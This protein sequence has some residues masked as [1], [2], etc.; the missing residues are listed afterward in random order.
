VL[1]ESSQERYSFL[2]LRCSRTW[3]WTYEVRIASDQAGNEWRMYF[4]GGRASS[5][6]GVGVSCPACGGLRVKFVPPSPLLLASVPTREDRR[7]DQAETG[8]DQAGASVGS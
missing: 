3:Q 6:P 8:G 7:T 1:I 4:R 5:A 2:C